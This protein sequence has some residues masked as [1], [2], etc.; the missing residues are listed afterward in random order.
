[1]PAN[2]FQ[3]MQAIFPKHPLQAGEVLSVS[4]G[5]A[6]VLLPGGWEIK[7]L[8]PATVGGH[9]FVRGGV[10]EGEAPSLA[11]VLIEI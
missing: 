1:M 8:G 6:T 11:A 2:L 9:V 3:E 4:G 7:A 10:I 5:L